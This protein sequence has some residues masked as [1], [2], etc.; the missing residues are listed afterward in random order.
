[1]RQY[2]LNSLYS[3]NASGAMPVLR[4]TNCALV[5]LP[6][7]HRVSLVRHLRR[8]ALAADARKAVSRRTC[9]V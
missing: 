4:G 2:L 8:R 5:I 9:D 3:L 6:L 7:G 1:M